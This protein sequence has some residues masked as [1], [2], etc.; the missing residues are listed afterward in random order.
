[1]SRCNTLFHIAAAESL[2]GS[3]YYARKS[4]NYVMELKN[5]QKLWLS[6]MLN[7]IRYHSIFS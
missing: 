3:K 4:V 7:Y 1:M 6:I 2:Y 5:S